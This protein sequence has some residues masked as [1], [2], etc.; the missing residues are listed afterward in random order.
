MREK[1]GRL[2]PHDGLAVVAQYATATSRSEVPD[3]DSPLV[4]HH[5]R[6]A[7]DALVDDDC[8][9]LLGQSCEPVGARERLHAADDDRAADVVALSG[10]EPDP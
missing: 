4:C 10:D 1:R 2:A 6:V 7:G 8:V 9:E 3:R 5:D